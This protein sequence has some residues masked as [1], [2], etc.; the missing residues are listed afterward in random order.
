[1]QWLSCLDRKLVR[2]LIRLGSQVLAI[3]LVIGCGV[4]QFITN[5]MSYDALRVTQSV[6]YD[7]SRFADIFVSLKRAPLSVADQI[8]GI[9]GIETVSPRI[10]MNLALDVPGLGEPATAQVVSVPESRQ[11][12]L[13][14]LYIRRGR[15]IEPGKR[16]EVL[17]SEAFVEANKLT[18]G[19]TVGAVINGRWTMLRIVGVAL[20]PEYV[21]EIQP[22]GLF[23]D[24]RRFGVFWMGNDSLAAAFDLEGAF[25]DASI[26][27][28]RGQA[29]APV[30]SG[31]DRIL[32][33]YGGLGAYS[34]SE[35]VSNRFLSDE[36]RQN[37]IFGTVIPGIF[38]AVAAFLI[39]TTSTRLVRLEREQIAI[40]KAFGFTNNSIAL[41]YMKFCVLVVSLGSV[42]GGLFGA[43]WASYVARI[44]GQFY[45]FPALDFHVRANTVILVVLVA[46][47]TAVAGSLSAARRA[48]ALPP[49]EAMR[50][51]APATFRRGLIEKSGL[52]PLFPIT[53]RIVVRNLARQPV[54]A[55]LS[56]LGIAF[57]TAIL[58]VG[59]YS[60]DAV[61]YMAETQFQHV[62]RDDATLLFKDPRPASI[63]LDISRLSP[64]LKSEPFRLVS[65]RIRHA[66]HSRRL[67]LTGLTPGGE[68][69]R[70]VGRDLLT[71]PVPERGVVITKKLGEILETKPGDVVTIEAL[72][73][74]RRVRE[75]MVAGLVDELLGLSAYM[76]I[77][78]VNAMM[79]EDRTA[80][81]AFVLMDA[82]RSDELYTRLKRLPVIAG[83]QLRKAAIASFNSTLAQSLGVFTVVLVVFSG[84][85]AFAAVYN[86]GRIALSERGREL[87]SL[88]VLG[89]TREEV[90]RM[91]IAEQAV[92]VGAA[93]PIG[94]LLGCWIAKALSDLYSWELFRMPFIITRASFGF[95]FITVLASAV[96][97]ALIVRRRLRRMDLVSVIKTRE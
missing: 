12:P 37:Q 52:A 3:A 62:Q 64:I 26:K 36:I 24:N 11:P 54:R 4:G 57:A 90:A 77:Q 33:P 97:S 72:E 15:Y 44:Y 73:G 45:R 93:L 78:D 82:L 14:R 49:A 81:G 55:L 71:V 5:R 17:A 84:V 80:S 8:R 68:L 10:V 19:S 92:L 23:P 59:H 66:Q 13:N 27:L 29:E 58:L 43:W 7:Q 6:Y 30:I 51:E 61:W 40:L 34:R 41:H 95:S 83:V 47:I 88:R 50:P 63:N 76:N 46:L 21:Y 94:F 70:L 28:I 56:A 22:G 86:S 16:D 79:N 38:M 2:D 35:Q 9:P 85:I 25:N 74:R 42:I 1:M 31:I 39:S 20:S 60:R 96:V 18:V 53:F 48:A 32:Q 67:A 91:L 69:R 65:I 87:A 75:V 89:F